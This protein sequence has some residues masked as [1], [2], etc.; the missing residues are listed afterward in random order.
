MK[1]APARV[2]DYSSADEMLA[3][4]Q[5]I[6]ALFWRQLMPPPAPPTIPPA[7]EPETIPASEPP[8][9]STDDDQTIPAPEPP[10]ASDN[11]I[12][13]PEKFAM[14]LRN[15]PSR[16]EQIVQAVCDEFHLTRSELFSHRR[17]APV[18][19]PRTLVFALARHL[20]RKSTPDIGRRAGGFDH[21]TVMHATRKRSHVLERTKD[22]M[23]EDA[24]V[25][26]WV[27]VMREHMDGGSD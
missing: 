20:T 25:A 5:S 18:V 15:P 26:E 10:P 3:K 2:P 19:A 21:P 4:Y 8:P 22:G 17:F 23:P 14:M 13:L 9:V 27:R 12:E 16:F 6:H 24:T 11:A 7:P 1:V